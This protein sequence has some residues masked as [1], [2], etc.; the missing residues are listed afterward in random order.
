MKTQITKSLNPISIFLT[1]TLA[2]S[3]IFYFLIIYSGMTGGRKG[4]YAT[5]IIVVSWD[6]GID[7]NE[8]L[9]EGY[10]ESWMEMGQMH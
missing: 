2:V 9:K 8:N 7:Y 5:G 1:I 10:F 3:S 6:F 4:L